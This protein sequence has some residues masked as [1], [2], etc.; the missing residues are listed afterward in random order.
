M[1]ILKNKQFR[2]YN[3]ISRYAG[4]PF[5]YNT[6]D[7]KYVYGTTAQL[8]T[9]VPYVLHK[10]VQNETLDSIA[11]DFYNNPTFFWVIADFNRIQDPYKKLKVG[12]ELKIPTLSD[13]SFE[14]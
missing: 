8:K 1:D 2:E 13:I 11:L 6:L 3:Y 12:E 14:E 5:Y 4:F 7:N 10:V 9:N